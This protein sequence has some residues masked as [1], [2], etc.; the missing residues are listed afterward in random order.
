MGKKKKNLKTTPKV[1]VWAINGVT[2]E[3]LNCW[4]ELVAKNLGQGNF[5]HGKWNILKNNLAVPKGLQLLL[6]SVQFCLGWTWAF[7]IQYSDPTT[8]M[9]AFL[10]FVQTW[11]EISI[12][13]CLEKAF[14]RKHSYFAGIFVSWKQRPR[15]YMPLNCS[16]QSQLHKTESE[17]PSFTTAPAEVPLYSSSM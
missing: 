6:T 2:A 13:Q 10:M 9:D 11:T 14:L 3:T 1:I 12:F 4:I 7:Y 8:V 16:V 15:Q 5:S 17:Y